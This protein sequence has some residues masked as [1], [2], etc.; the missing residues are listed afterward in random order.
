MC[1]NNVPQSEAALSGRAVEGLD[2]SEEPA[3]SSVRSGN[4]VIQKLLANKEE[5]LRR[6]EKDPGPNE[7]EIERL[8]EKIN[9]AL[10]LLDGPEKKDIA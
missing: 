4:G 3:T 6:P 5:L 10:D 7:R 9:T 8:L 1:V 2:Q